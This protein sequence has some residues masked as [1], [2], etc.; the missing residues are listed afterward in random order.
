MA[1]RL[2]MVPRHWWAL[3]LRG[4][5]AVVFG[6]LAYAW[7]GLTLAVLVLLFG[8]YALA[9]GVLAII[10]AIRSNGD[11]LWALLLEGIAGILAGV[12]VLSWPG[13]SAV[14]LLYLIASWAIITGVLEIWSAVRLRKVIENEWAWIIGG[15][16]SVIFG[17]IM[18]ASPGAGA[19]A[20][21]WIIGIYAIVAGVMLLVLSWRVRDLEQKERARKAGPSLRQPAAL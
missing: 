14:L 2:G 10:S 3:A 12:A 18:L 20:L 5:A 9:D 15:L 16:A 19:L 13:L 17:A 6:I 11:H 21:V 8:A 7:P 4:L 1:M